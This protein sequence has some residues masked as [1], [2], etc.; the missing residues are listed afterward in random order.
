MPIPVRCTCGQSFQAKDALAGR[1]AKCPKCAQ[2][3]LI[4][5]PT[6][7]AGSGMDDDLWDEIGLAPPVAGPQCPHCS[8]ELKPGAI[9]CVSCGTNLQTG[10]RFSTLVGDPDE[11]ARTGESFGNR[12]LD[13]A[14]RRME[15][16][17]ELQDSMGTGM[18]WWVLL[19]IFLGICTFIVAMLLI[20]K[21]LVMY[22]SAMLLFIGGG[23]TSFVAAVWITVIA[24]QD[25]TSKG[26]MCLLV[27]FYMFY[28]VFTNWDEVGGLFIIWLIGNGVNT[29]GY[30]MFFLASLFAG[31]DDEYGSREIMPRSAVVA[32]REVFEWAPVAAS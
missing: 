21:S 31:D 1:T 9:L 26:V 13:R 29:V 7:P 12:D 4:P 6:P 18:P 28:Y 2:P 23:L 17:Q 10:E 16:D 24:F 22:V 11:R 8:A 27:P 32:S 20:P 3:I 5:S 30:A 25:S 14:A 19:L 15:E